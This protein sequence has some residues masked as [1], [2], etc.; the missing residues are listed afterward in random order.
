MRYWSASSSVALALLLLFV[1][2][3]VGLAI[4]IMARVWNWRA[5]FDTPLDVVFLLYLES[6]RALTTLAGVVIAFLAARRARSRPAFGVLAFGI[7]FATLAYT[8]A[9]AFAGFPGAV[10]ERAALWLGAHGV[11]HLL[12]RVLFAHPEW[13]CWPAL[14]AFTLFAVRYPHA[15]SA[16]DIARSGARDRAGALRSVVLAGLDVGRLARNAAAAALRRGWLRGGVVWAAALLAAVAHTAALRAFRAPLAI[17]LLALL[18]A[19]LP[20]AVLVALFRASHEAADAGER[21][22]LRWLRRG[23]FAALTLFVT[24]A[25]ATPLV[26]RLPLGAVALSL[27]PAALAACW[28]LAVLRAPRLPGAAP[29]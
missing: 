12:L 3:F 13:A 18:I 25:L 2:L 15:L 6:L 28:L 29:A 23:V 5:T 26:P 27:A 8:K 16:E 4:D 21:V 20:I 17:N 9:I 10:Q 11:P 24:S 14:A 1:L 22:P 19:L 7:G